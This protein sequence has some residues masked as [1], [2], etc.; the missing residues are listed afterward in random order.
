MVHRLFGSNLVKGVVRNIP[1]IGKESEEN[2]NTLAKE[3]KN[4]GEIDVLRFVSL[5]SLKEEP[6]FKLQ[7]KQAAFIA[8]WRLYRDK[9]AVTDIRA[10]G[11]WSSLMQL[12]IHFLNVY[13]QLS[14][15][16]VTFS[17]PVEINVE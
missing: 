15:Q 3:F 17:S 1:N 14:S 8:E 7:A 10:T 5:C 4:I 11:L 16:L 2:P 13:R 12:S 9:G 6:R